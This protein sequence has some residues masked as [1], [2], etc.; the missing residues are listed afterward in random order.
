MP[1]TIRIAVVRHENEAD[2]APAPVQQ[3][4]VILALPPGREC[5]DRQA[6]MVAFEQWAR[7]K[8]VL[9]LPPIPIVDQWAEHAGLDATAA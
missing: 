3:G 6:R 1:M 8:P 2:R 4:L 9:A 5:R 7:S